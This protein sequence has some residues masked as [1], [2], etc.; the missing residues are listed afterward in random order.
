MNAIKQAAAQYRQENPDHQGGVVLIY[1]CEAYGWKDQLRDPQSEQPGTYAVA[2]DGNAWVAVGGNNYDGAERWEAI[3]GE[4]SERSQPAVIP[5]S[6]VP[7]R[8]ATSENLAQTHRSLD[9]L[10]GMA[11]DLIDEAANAKIQR[12]VMN[13]DHPKGRLGMMYTDERT[14]TAEHI[15]K[16]LNEAADKLLDHAYTLTENTAD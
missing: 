4:P 7:G 15:A 14:A 3:Q 9:I 11:T 1:Q 12:S 5:I 10:R 13:P 16:V 8:D 6:W 2:E